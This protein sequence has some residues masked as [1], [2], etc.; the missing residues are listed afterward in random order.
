MK[1][2]SYTD[3]RGQVYAIGKSWPGTKRNVIIQTIEP[4]P[5]ED[6]LVRQLEAQGIEVTDEM[7]LPVP[8]HDVTVI[9]EEAGAAEPIWI[10]QFFFDGA[11]LIYSATAAEFQQMQQLGQER[12][13]AAVQQP[14]GNAP[15]EPA[16]EPASQPEATP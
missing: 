7:S 14:D 6:D 1:L 16:P 5:T 8:P 13:N 4:S 15:T 3:N 12:V 11:G 2:K 9:G 10:G